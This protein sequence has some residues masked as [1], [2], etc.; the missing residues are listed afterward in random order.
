M[1]LDEEQRAELFGCESGLLAGGEAG[2]MS[3]SAWPT[4]RCPQ[5]LVVS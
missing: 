4:L 3:G 5:S 1:Q 2:E